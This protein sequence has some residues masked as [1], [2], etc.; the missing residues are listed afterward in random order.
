MLIYFFF[1]SPLLIYFNFIISVVDVG[2]PT[3]FS[4]EGL[5]TLKE[6]CMIEHLRVVKYQSNSGHPISPT[7]IIMIDFD[8]ILEV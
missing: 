2:F 4:H 5:N 8:I 3:P 1:V 6:G 7:T